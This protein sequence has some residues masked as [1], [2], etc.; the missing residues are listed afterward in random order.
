MPTFSH[1][2]FKAL[3]SLMSIFQLKQT[4]VDPVD[5]HGVIKIQLGQPDHPLISTYLTRLDQALVAWGVLTA[6]IFLTAH[7]Y[8]LDWYTQAIVWSGLSCLAI[9][10]SGK[11]TWF[12]VTTRNQRWILYGWSSLILMGLVLTDYGIFVSWGMVLRHLCALWLGISALGYV[13]TGVG[14]QAPA[15]ILI[16]AA[17]IGTIPL[18]TLL[19]VPQFLLTGAVMTLSLFS[20]AAFHWEHQ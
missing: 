11:L 13:I 6:I 5:L 10:I 17:H 12:W 20:L 19:P 2:T 1:N 9:A 7:F 14:I 16:G 18:L 8:L 15:L 3:L 4:L